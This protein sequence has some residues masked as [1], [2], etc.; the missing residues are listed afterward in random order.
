[1]YQDNYV[2]D[3]LGGC[4]SSDSDVRIIRLEA[5][6][7]R[8]L[9]MIQRLYQKVHLVAG[10]STGCTQGTLYYRKG[11]CQGHQLRLDIR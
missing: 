2:Y 8:H 5:E 6:L 7:R 11:A 3:L 9:A 4:G 10:S 1:M